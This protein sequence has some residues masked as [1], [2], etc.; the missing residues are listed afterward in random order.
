ERETDVPRTVLGRPTRFVG[1]DLETGTLTGLY[2]QVEGEAVARVA[3]V[4]GAPGLGKSRLREEVVHSLRARSQSP[5]IWIAAAEALGSG[6][7][8][9]VASRLV[10]DGVVGT[11]AAGPES[12]NASIAERIIE[13]VERRVAPEDAVRVATFLAELARVPLDA[14]GVTSKARP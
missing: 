10:R 5:Q 1:R 9:G 3:I 4:T 8:L 2:N 11:V 14:P 12:G 6:S 7:P 13:R